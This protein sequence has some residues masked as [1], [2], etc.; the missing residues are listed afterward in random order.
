MVSDAAGSSGDVKSTG[1]TNSLGATDLTRKVHV[2][3]EG[4]MRKYGENVGEDTSE[5]AT[6]ARSYWKLK[7]YY[8]LWIRMYVSSSKCLRCLVHLNL[9]FWIE[10]DTQSRNSA[11]YFPVLPTLISSKMLDAKLMAS[12]TPLIHKHSKVIQI[13]N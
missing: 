6:S 2:S 11:D 10:V 3:F 5:C 7:M 9:P 4:R 13:F 8:E 12:Q 1:S